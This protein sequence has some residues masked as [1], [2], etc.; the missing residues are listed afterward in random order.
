[1]KPTLLTHAEIARLVTLMRPLNLHKFTVAA[2][3][4]VRFE[5]MGGAT[6]A[7]ATN[8]DNTVI[9]PNALERGGED[10]H[11]SLPFVLLQ[12]IAREADRDQPVT[13]T[14]ADSKALVQW[15]TQGMPMEQE[16]AVM[17]REDFPAVDTT[18]FNRGM[19]VPRALLD[20]L[21][22]ARPSISTDETRWVFNGVYL[23]GDSQRVVSTDGRRLFCGVVPVRLPCNA[24]VPTVALEHLLRAETDAVWFKIEGEG[25]GEKGEGEDIPVSKTM[26]EKD[27]RWEKFCAKEAP[28]WLP[29][30]THGMAR[31][32]GGALLVFR[33]I[34]G[35]FPNWKQVVPREAHYCIAVEEPETLL[36]QL[37][38]G[39]NGESSTELH[40]NDSHQ[41]QMRLCI[42]DRK[43]GGWMTVGKV[44]QEKPSFGT[45]RLNTAFLH[46]AL[47]AAVKP[48]L[49]LIDEI[50]P[51]VV[52]SADL[53]RQTVVMPMRNN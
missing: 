13:V 52:Q 7:F 16:E 51:A 23:D 21:S 11:L 42:K 18:G 37:Q 2:L 14:V 1:M 48:V 22:A 29:Q 39:L 46:S 12:R 24:I 9:V 15:Q 38:V 27:R 5:T 28:K 10:G 32:Q 6:T 47:T 25:K 43:P 40:L 31:L 50:S 30:A 35:N 4:H 20:V 17:P 19:M 33:C 8:L 49:Y 53:T 45:M 36:K 34:E 44:A 41:A 26:A 3:H